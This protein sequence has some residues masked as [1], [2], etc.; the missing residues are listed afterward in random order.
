MAITMR[1]GLLADFKPSRMLPGEW[2]VSIDP[3]TKNQV[4]YMCFAAGVVKRMGTL[5]DFEEWFTASFEAAI[6]PYEKQFTSIKQECEE[7]QENVTTIG[8]DIVII[9]D[10]IVNSY[11]P[12]IQQYAQ[13]V[14]DTKDWIDN[15]FNIDVSKKSTSGIVDTY[16]ITYQN[17]KT[18]DFDVTNGKDGE[19]GING[20][21]AYQIAVDEGF[22]GTEAE[23]LAS[24]K[25]EKGD[26]GQSSPIASQT[27]PGIVKI[28]SDNTIWIDP[29]GTIHVAAKVDVDDELSETS[30]NPVQNKVITSE[31]LSL[32][33]NEIAFWGT[34]QEWDDLPE[35]E[36]DKCD[37]KGVVIKDDYSATVKSTI[38]Q[39]QASTNPND[40]AGASALVELDNNL[41]EYEVLATITNGG[42]GVVKEISQAL[43][44][45]ITKYRFLVLT[46]GWHDTRTD[47]IYMMNS[48]AL[49]V[50]AFKNKFGLFCNVYSSRRD[51][52]YINYATDTSINVTIYSG[53]DAYLL[54]IK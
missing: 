23:W 8:G 38:A 46:I 6:S 12:Q 31:I 1:K 48:S 52:V 15:N 20:K 37:G 21:S 19:D 44:D 40:V 18:F 41:G 16:E 39:C 11:L 53:N 26:P 30:E 3:D 33:I 51:Y 47:N 27:E 36:K 49:P 32:K 45:N 9:S 4:V 25:G 34:Q 43:L 28:P 29:D 10:S 7:I 2:A 35:D 54:G 42:S 5:E 14:Q 24:L 50:K 17:T 22:V 13:E